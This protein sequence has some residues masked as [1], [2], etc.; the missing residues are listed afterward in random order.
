MKH[1]FRRITPPF[2][3]GPLLMDDVHAFEREHPPTLSDDEVARRARNH[4]TMRDR[5]R[6]ALRLSFSP[7]ERVW[8]RAAVMVIGLYWAGLLL[9]LALR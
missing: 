5:R 2:T 3:P 6:R 8:L 1:L 4:E 9:W 7:G